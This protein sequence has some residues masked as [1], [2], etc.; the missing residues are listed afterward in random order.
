LAGREPIKKESKQTSR[1]RREEQRR[2]EHYNY[3]IK[4][5][6][7]SYRSAETEKVEAVE[8]EGGTAPKG[9]QNAS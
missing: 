7:A 8:L 2:R 1:T 3:I 9:R 6:G 4:K 5:R